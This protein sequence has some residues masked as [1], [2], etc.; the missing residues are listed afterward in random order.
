MRKIREWYAKFIWRMFIF[1]GTKIFHYVDVYCPGTDNAPVLGITFTNDR[2]YLA[3]VHSIGTKGE[4]E[5]IKK[6]EREFLINKF[7]EFIDY[8]EGEK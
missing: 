6:L 8:L 1:F 7:Y 2:D 3:K 4:G 5:T